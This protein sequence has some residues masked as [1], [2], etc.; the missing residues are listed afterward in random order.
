M[1]NI[2]STFFP[3]EKKISLVSLISDAIFWQSKGDLEDCMRA[4]TSIIKLKK[5]LVTKEELIMLCTGL[6]N[7]RK[8]LINYEGPIDVQMIKNKSA[9]AGL[10][11]E[12]HNYFIKINE[13]EPEEIENWKNIAFDENEFVEIRNQWKSE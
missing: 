12:I 10:A 13:K 5:D 4:Y 2:D 8:T 9:A 3:S 7:I 1:I 11:H 6:S